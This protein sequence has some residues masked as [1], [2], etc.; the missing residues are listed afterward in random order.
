VAG[1][2]N[3]TGCMDAAFVF[4]PFCTRG[5]GRVE[6]HRP[7]RPCSAKR[8]ETEWASHA[9]IAL[10]GLARDEGHT[11]TYTTT[12]LSPCPHSRNTC[13]GLK[14]LPLGGARRPLGVPSAV[15]GSP[16]GI[17]SAAQWPP[18]HPSASL[19]HGRWRTAAPSSANPAEG[20]P[21]SSSLSAY[22]GLLPLDALQNRHHVHLAHTDPSA[23]PCAIGCGPEVPSQM[24]LA[25]FTANPNLATHGLTLLANGGF[26]SDQ[27][28]TYL[29]KGRKNTQPSPMGLRGVAWGRMGWFRETAL[30][31]ASGA[32]AQEQAPRR[33]RAEDVPGHAHGIHT[34]TSITYPHTS[35]VC[36][37]TIRTPTPSSCKDSAV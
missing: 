26:Q 18:R 22:W 20:P 16:R 32:F 25:P 13:G 15:H 3:A 7:C 8:A 36:G 35:F 31:V 17:P 5:R 11:I 12:T 10:D 23:G 28:R 37:S 6:A 9:I 24:G 1:S 34:N 30:S 21:L 2:S 19:G 29:L 27:Q 4:R 14:L 33:C